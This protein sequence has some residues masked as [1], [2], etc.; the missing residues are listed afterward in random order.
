MMDETLSTEVQP[1]PT[2]NIR[3]FFPFSQIRTKQ[4]V[5]LDF[6][7]R[8]VA[9]GYR[10]VVIEAPTG[11]GKTGCGVAAG[12]WSRET[13]LQGHPGAYY[14]VTQK[15][16]Q[17]QL[18][19]DFEK[20]RPRYRHDAASIKSAVEYPC[21]QYGNCLVG[22]AI[23]DKSKLC[24]SLRAKSCGY[25][26]AYDRFV[27][28]N[29]SVTNYPYFFTERTYVGRLQPRQTLVLDEA[30]NIERQVFSFVE[31]E[32]SDTYLEE[33]AP[34]LRPMPE[35]AHLHQLQDW[36]VQEYLPVISDRLDM[37]QSIQ[38]AAQ[39]EGGSVTDKEASELRRLSTH[40]ARALAA[41]EHM[42]QD[43][44]NWVFW[45]E[46]SKEKGSRYVAKPVDA[47]PFTDSLLFSYGDLKIFMSAYLGPKDLFCRSLGLDPGQVAFASLSST[48]PVANRPVHMRFVGSMG[49]K[50]IEE[51]LPYLLRKIDAI[52]THHPHERGLIHSHTYKIGKAIYD[53]LREGPHKDRVLFATQAGQRNATLFQHATGTAPTIL[54][55]P[56]M[57]EGFSFDD[58]LAR[59]QVLA[60]C[61][62]SDSQAFTTSGLKHV[63]KIQKGDYVFALDRGGKLVQTAV[64]RVIRVPYKGKMLHFKHSTASMCLTPDHRVLAKK[65]KNF[66]KRPYE[67]IKAN[68]PALLS[69]GYAF[70]VKPESYAG[71]KLE[72]ISLERWILPDDLLILKNPTVRT[73]QTYLEYLSHS[74]GHRFWKFKGRERIPEAK[75]LG[76]VLFQGRRQCKPSSIVYDAADFLELVGWYVAEG[77]LYGT[78][79]SKGVQITQK[80]QKGINAIKLLLDKMG[81][82]WTY[83]GKDFKIKSDLLYRFFQSEI[84]GRSYEKRIPRW[85][86][87][88]DKNCL[89]HLLNSL[90]AGDGRVVP[91]SVRYYTVSEAL[92]HNVCEIALKT[93]YA[94]SLKQRRIKSGRTLFIT[95]LHRHKYQTLKRKYAHWKDYAGKVWCLTT[96]HGNFL[97]EHDGK[98]FF[99]GNC[100]FANLG[101]PQI[102]A[103]KEQ[104]PEWYTLQTVSTVIQS[105]GRIIRSDSDHGVS[106]LLDSDFER[107]FRQNE[108]FFPRWLSAAFHW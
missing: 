106:Y 5:A 62:S 95:V 20:F 56:S 107:L 104:D 57:S 60:K 12:L 92:A 59:W 1:P 70:P 69:A 41:T 29:V 81:L 26:L 9:L 87:D 78:P 73:P 53:H 103:K 83:T 6:I 97:A 32:V 93:G 94:P 44:D 55:S 35:L 85:I 90:L 31:I 48:F 67:Y 49:R 47:S 22:R 46:D 54:I 80:K 58:D 72:K 8:A 37:L 64:L 99:T 74:P 75:R 2:A 84:P 19:K 4:G 100:P 28:R 21:P 66:E 23:K 38:E 105:L 17:D 3:D 82:Y 71:T 101:D 108:H 42:A 50:S 34:H 7:Q 40:Y 16:L 43:P 15:L 76:E 14:L 79:S 68:D 77:C 102:Q 33:W 13:D 30:H 98:L 39:E 25:T 11:V 24:Q 88:L 18:E 45:K 36:L 65:T 91:N 52:A 86:L 96:E 51:T 63:S 27:G 89:E 10:N 61:L